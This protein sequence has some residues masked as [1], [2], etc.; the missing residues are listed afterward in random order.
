VRGA[1]NGPSGVA[2]ASN[3]NVYIADSANNAVRML[4]FAGYQ[5]SIAAGAN[6][7]SNL[8][9]PVSGGEVLVLYGA[10]MG[11]GGLSVATVG[12]NGLYPTSLNGVTV[13]IG[14][15]AAP[16]LYTSP[17]QVA[18]VV[19]FEVSGETTQAFVQY[20]GQFSAPFPVTLAQSTP[21]IFTANLSGQGQAA[22]INDSNN[23]F[24][25]NNSANPA[26]AGDYIEIYVTGAGQTSPA[27]VDGQPYAG[28][29]NC[30][31]KASVTIGGVTESPQYCGGVPG[32]IAG[33]TQ[34]NVPVPVGLPAGNVP[35]SVTIGGVTAQ[36]GVTVAVSGH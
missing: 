7:A 16:I 1:L 24:T 20:Q 35:I 36:S 5:L 9:G 13:T 12:T 33:L 29:A 25:Y 8:T 27:G 21:G 4:V 11:P 3:G 32:Q 31:L 15:Y 2:V 22:A 23:I 17:T 6:S 30:T 18:V 14:G 28:L 26:N 19:P 34:I 10:G